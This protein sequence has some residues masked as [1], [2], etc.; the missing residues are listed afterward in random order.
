M[1]DPVNLGPGLALATRKLRVDPNLSNKLELL[2]SL[3]LFPL[4]PPS[5]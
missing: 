5:L 1:L 2:D 4:F 3:T